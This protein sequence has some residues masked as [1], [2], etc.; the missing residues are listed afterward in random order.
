MNTDVSKLKEAGHVKLSTHVG[1]ELLR[2]LDREF[3]SVPRDRH[4]PIFN[5]EWATCGNYDRSR[6]MVVTPL[7]PADLKDGEIDLPV[8]R[9]FGVEVARPLILEAH[10]EAAACCNSLAFVAVYTEEDQH[11]HRDLLRSLVQGQSHYG[12]H[13]L[14]NMDCP[15]GATGTFVPMSEA[16]FPDPWLE[17]PT[18][19]RRGDVTVLGGLVV[20]K[21]GRKAKLPGA[22]PYRLIA[23]SAFGTHKY[24]YNAQG[25]WPALQKAAF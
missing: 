14:V 4:I 23:F 12:V 3:Q 17:V 19:E 7:D 15:E 10:P 8:L 18:L 6:I 1:G 9:R 20:H 25:T 16:G 5:K 21:G 13:L 11:E 22:P 2:E 24:N